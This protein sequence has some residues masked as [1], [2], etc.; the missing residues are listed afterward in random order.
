VGEAEMRYA[1]TN[2]ANYYRV[3][4]GKEEDTLVPISPPKEVAQSILTLKAEDLP[5]P[6]IEDIVQIPVLRPDGSLLDTPGYYYSG[7]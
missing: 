4:P 2:S 3:K 7:K 6:P 1:L 5:F